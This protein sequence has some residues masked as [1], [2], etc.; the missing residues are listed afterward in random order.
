MNLYLNESKWTPTAKVYLEA[1]AEAK[2]AERKQLRRWSGGRRTPTHCVP[3]SRIAIIIPYCE[4]ERHLK[5]FLAHIISFLKRQ[6]VDFQII[7]I[8]QV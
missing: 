5:I 1:A 4:R 7:V 2:D 8:E 3:R 6:L